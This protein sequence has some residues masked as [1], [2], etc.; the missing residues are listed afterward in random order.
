MSPLW[1]MMI[2]D[3]GHLCG[4]LRLPYLKL[5]DLLSVQLP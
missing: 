3:T 5:G 4:I 2:M 1:H